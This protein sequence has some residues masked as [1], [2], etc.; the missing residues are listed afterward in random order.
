MASIDRAQARVLEGSFAFQGEMA[1]AIKHSRTH[2][3]LWSRSRPPASL[4]EAL[5]TAH[6]HKAEIDNGVRRPGDRCLLPAGPGRGWPTS[7]T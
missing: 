5:G 7:P 1:P 3:G 6:L 4:L 2:A